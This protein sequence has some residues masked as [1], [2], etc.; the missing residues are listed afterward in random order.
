MRWI[1][2]L[3]LMSIVGCASQNPG[4]QTGAWRLPNCNVQVY[5][6]TPVFGCN[7]GGV[8]IPVGR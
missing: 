7:T 4:P 5:G 2:A 3:L 6:K 8:T 1:I